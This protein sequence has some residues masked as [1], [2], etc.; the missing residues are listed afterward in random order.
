[1]REGEISVHPGLHG[2][3]V[4]WDPSKLRLNVQPKM[5]LT[6]EHL[7]MEGDSNG[8]QRFHDW[9]KRRDQTIEQGSH[10]TF[11]IVIASDG[12]P[13][14]STITVDTQS[15]PKQAGRPSGRRFGT[16][17][18]AILRD[19]DLQAE[20]EA[21][22][23]LAGSHGRTLGAPAAEVKAASA[24]VEAVLAHPLIQSARQAERC[25]R[26]SPVTLPL[27]NGKMLEGTIDLAYFDGATWTIVD[28]KTAADIAS[29][30]T[31]YE[32]QLQWYAAAFSKI[33]GKPTRAVLFA[34]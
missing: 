33:T 7:L 15:I 27:P 14:A 28:F 25:L 6:N 19:V 17:V 18:H 30:R 8:L 21:I 2:E 9:R 23:S 26:E 10:K 32:R 24:T 13:M 3:V 34:L 1:M 29:K 31:H 11:E 22:R 4:W 5:G 12:S 20:A 16:L